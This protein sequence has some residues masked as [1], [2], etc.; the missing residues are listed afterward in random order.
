M[1]LKQKGVSTAL[2]FTPL[3]LLSYYKHKYELKVNA[4]P[5]ALSNYQQILSLP[6]YAKMNDDEVIYV[7]KAIKD[8]LKNRI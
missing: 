8:I 3:H 2:H 1:K 7:C 4:Y 6:I 5:K